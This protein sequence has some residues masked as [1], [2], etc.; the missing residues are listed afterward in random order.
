MDQERPGP[1]GEQRG[2]WKSQRDVG[3]RPA[4]RTLKIVVEKRNVVVRDAD[5]E[6][7]RDERATDNP[8]T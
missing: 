6:A 2:E 1:Q 3:A 4:V 7:G 5:R 8:P